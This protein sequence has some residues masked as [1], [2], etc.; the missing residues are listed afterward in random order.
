MKKNVDKLS[1]AAEMRAHEAEVS[2]AQVI[3]VLVVQVVLYIMYSYRLPSMQ[4]PV[5]QS[6]LT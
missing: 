3:V 2:H 4:A 5:G 1:R 6:L